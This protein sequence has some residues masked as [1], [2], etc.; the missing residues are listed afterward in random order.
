MMKR[1]TATIAW[2]VVTLASWGQNT[3]GLIPHTSVEGYGGSAGTTGAGTAIP[4]FLHTPP[5]ATASIAAGDGKLY[6]IIIN[7]HGAEAKTTLYST[8]QTVSTGQLNN[9]DLRPPIRQLRHA[10]S[11]LYGKRYAAFGRTDSTQFFYFAPQCWG[12]Y[13]FFYQF[14]V[15]ESLQWIKANLSHIVDTNRIY[16]TG[17]SLGGGGVNIAMQDSNINR[18]I[19]AAVSICPGYDNY[20]GMVPL[21]NFGMLARSG[22]PMIFLHAA[23]DPD[24]KDCGGGAGCSISMVSN[25]IANKPLV[26]PVFF[27]YP[28]GG[29]N[30]WDRAWL[31]YY[32]NTNYTLMSGGTANMSFNIHAWM[33]QYST[34]GKRRPTGY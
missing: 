29:H 2:L 27:Y 9:L 15:N 10:D 19:A 32:A 8:K 17:L 16:L 25:L 30:M 21:T 14:Y 4:W 22:A 23:N 31:P 7:L 1:L 13:T 3:T 33:L 6:P 34:H 11:I 5:D 12:G 20:S 28:T 18:Q 24:T 26:Q